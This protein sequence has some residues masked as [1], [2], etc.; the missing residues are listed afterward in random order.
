MQKLEED[1]IKLLSVKEVAGWFFLKMA[2]LSPQRNELV[3]TKTPADKQYDVVEL[4]KSMIA[5]F[6]SMHKSESAPSHPFVRQ[7]GR[8]EGNYSSSSSSH[9]PPYKSVNVLEQADD[10]EYYEDDD[11]EHDG[12]NSTWIKDSAR[13]ELEALAAEL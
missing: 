10:E 2:A 11:W 5:L 6:P 4:K 7:Y 8:G 13:G 9:K 3:L 1:G 12:D